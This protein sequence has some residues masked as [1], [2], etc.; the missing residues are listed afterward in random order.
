MSW[1]RLRRKRQLLMQFG[2]AV[3]QRVRA[4]SL[5]SADWAAFPMTGGFGPSPM[6]AD[7]SF[8]EMAREQ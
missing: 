1:L 8:D 7:N 2:Q 5:G 3:H 6:A 4:N